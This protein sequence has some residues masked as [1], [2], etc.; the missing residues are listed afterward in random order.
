MLALIL[1]IVGISFRFIPH[2]ANF[3]PLLAIALFG[4][5]YLKRRYALIVPVALMMLTDIFLGM[6]SA[7]AFTWGS[8][9]LISALGITLRKKK[10]TLSI[11]TGT[12]GSAVLF[13]IIT[14]FGVWAA[15]WYPKTLSGLVSCYTLAIPFFR[16]TLVSTTVF[17]FVFFGVYELVARRVKDSSLAG[18][19]L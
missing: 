5:V 13:F 1:V 15:G 6:H 11:I 8:I 14:N 3:S 18:A 12:I 10:N 17:S 7:I 2:L 19:L 4:G 16:S 9:I